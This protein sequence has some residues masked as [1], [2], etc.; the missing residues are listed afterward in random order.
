MPLVRAL[1]AR[2]PCGCCLHI[3]L[4][5]GNIED[6][7]VKFCIEFAK[8]ENCQECIELG[9]KLLLMSKTQRRQLY[10]KNSRP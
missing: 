4:D 1:Y 2:H 9:N 6:G 8:E 10:L 3:V 7:H 5:D